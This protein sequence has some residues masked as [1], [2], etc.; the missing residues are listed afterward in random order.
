MEEYISREQRIQQ[1]KEELQSMDYI[2]LKAY[3]GQNCEQYGDW[4]SER[5]EIRDEI[6]SLTAMSDEEWDVEVMV[7]TLSAI[8]ETVKQVQIQV[9]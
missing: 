8:A 1:L 9:I 7:G 4:K 2:A 6:N 3:E 5:Q